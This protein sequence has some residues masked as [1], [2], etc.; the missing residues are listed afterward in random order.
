MTYLI[1]ARGPLSIKTP[2]MPPKFN[3][4]IIFLVILLISLTKESLSEEIAIEADATTTIQVDTRY[5]SHFDAEEEW[6]DDDDEEE[7]EDNEE[8]EREDDDDDDDD[9]EEWDEDDDKDEVEWEDSADDEKA[10][11][12]RRLWDHL[13][14][15]EIFQS[16]RPI[17]DQSTWSNARQVYKKIVGEESSLLHDSES[18]GFAVPIEA[19]Q[20]PGKGRG[21]FAARDIKKTT[22]IWNTK[23]TA[24]FQDGELYRE[25]IFA[26]ETGF[27]CDVLQ[28]AYVQD[29]G[30]DKEEDNYDDEEYSDLHIS[31]DLDEGCFCNDGEEPNLGCD[32]EAA[33]EFPGG[34]KSNYFALRDIEAGEELIC[35]YYSFVRPDGWKEFGL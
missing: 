34:C 30:D 9:E 12:A 15:T 8:R 6:D 20:A 3:H 16:E 24:R 4:L 5:Q 1:S 26:L 23:Q 28:W 27:A 2:A 22:L 21:I 19:K 25:F 33:E 32:R 13:G 7:W 35:S 11:T 29:L 18:T 31:V 14:C 10:Y 17:H